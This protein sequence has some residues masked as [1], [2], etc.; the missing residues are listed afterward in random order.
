MRAIRLKTEYLSAPI[1]I[2]I[3]SPRLFWNCQGGLHQTAYRIQAKTEDGNLLWDSGKV[4][5][6]SAPLPEQYTLDLSCI[7]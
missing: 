2:D 6:S 5:N 4:E 3:L 7:S 1:G